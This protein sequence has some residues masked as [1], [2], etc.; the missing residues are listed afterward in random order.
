MRLDDELRELV[1]SQ[2]STSVLR[3]EC[4]RRGM[5]T[6]RESGLMSLYDGLTTLDEVTRETILDE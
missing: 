3:V 1:I 2:A 5:R 4:R 6:L